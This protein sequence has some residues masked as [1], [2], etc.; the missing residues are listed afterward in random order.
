MSETQ[1]QLVTRQFGPR[2]A[3]YLTSAVHAAGEDL[4]QLAAIV[5]GAGTARLLDLGC[6]AGHVAFAVAPAVAEVVAYDLSA[7]MLAVG[8]ESAAQRGLRHLVPRPG[9]GGRLALAGRH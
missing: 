5:A 4:Q 8:A 9:G 2:A 1:E 7:D 3:D 6:G